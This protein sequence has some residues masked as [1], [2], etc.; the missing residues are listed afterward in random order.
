MQANGHEE[1]GSIGT[2]SL[3]GW[4]AAPLKAA[5]PQGVAQFVRRPQLLCVSTSVLKEALTL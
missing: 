4:S 1:R 5:T 3:A 2:G